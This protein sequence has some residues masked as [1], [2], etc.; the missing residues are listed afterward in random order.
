MRG[1]VLSMRVYNKKEM[2]GEENNDHV[3]MGGKV[4]HDLKN[5]PLCMS[6]ELLAMRG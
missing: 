3:I 1:E 2:V 5:L 4:Y 6:F